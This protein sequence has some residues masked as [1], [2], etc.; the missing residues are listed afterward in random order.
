MLAKAN[1]LLKNHQE[2]LV[3]SLCNYDDEVWDFPLFPEAN[4]IT[5]M[6]VQFAIMNSEEF[7]NDIFYYKMQQLTKCITQ[8]SSLEDVHQSFWVPLF[9]HCCTVAD[10]IKRE[11]IALSSLSELFGS[12]ESAD[13]EKTIERLLAA[14]EKC[15]APCTKDIGLL[16]DLCVQSDIHKLVTLI[17]TES[18]NMQWVK[19]LG[20]KITDWSNV[21]TLTNEADHLMETLEVYDLTRSLVF[22]FSKEVC[23]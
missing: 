19:K 4:V 7:T 11:T 16:T 21:Q 6:L 15:H 18:L 10:E 3:K 23:D 8:E 17:E 13:S 12:T 22:R 20:K 9:D 5:P 1:D 14:V 2:Y